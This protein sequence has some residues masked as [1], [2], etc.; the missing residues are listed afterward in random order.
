MTLP[1]ALQDREQQKFEEVAGEV[2][3]RTK[4]VGGSISITGNSTEA[5]QDVGN[6]SLASI[7]TKL[8]SPIA[9]T[10]SFSLPSGA[11]TSALQTDGNASLTSIDGKFGSLGQKAM[12]GSAPVVI[13]SDQS[14]VPVSGTFWQATQ[15]VS[16]TVTAT[17]GT[18]PWVTSATQSGTW[19]I[20]DISGTVSL[21][22]GAATSALQTTGNTSLSSID[23]KLPALGQALAAASIPVVLT[24]AQLATLT[25]GALT[26]LTPSSKTAVSIGTSSTSA[27]SSNS[28]RKGL[29]LTNTSTNIMSFGLGE[30][31]I[32]NQG[33]T[34]YPGGTWQMDASTFTTVAINAVAGAGASVLAVQEF[35]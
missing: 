7:D 33:I 3:V 18:S 4:L 6:A 31:A 2:A 22:T 1:S 25:P 8:T 30:S 19:N 27:V 14:A 26:A 20:T 32:L 29:V 28:S 21:P 35:T 10:A 17:Q 15:P 34:L 24:A 23:G 13:A 16:G 11:S 12:T 9:V 5:K